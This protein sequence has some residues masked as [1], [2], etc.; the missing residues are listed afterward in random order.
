M[1]KPAIMYQDQIMKKFNSIM[2]TEDYYYYMGYVNC[3]EQLELVLQDDKVML[4]SVDKDENVIGL[5]KYMTNYTNSSVGR[6]GI[7]SFDKG[8][9]IF[10]TDLLKEFDKLYHKFHR[11]E[12][13]MVGSNPV[14]RHYDYI[15]RKYGGYVSCSHDCIRHPNG[16]YEDSYHYE[17]INNDIK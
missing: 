11:I 12:W 9:V 13:W 5:I 7:I 2:Y 4:A 10:G 14:K 16:E 17:I 15:T 8:N 1:L 3:G 6:F